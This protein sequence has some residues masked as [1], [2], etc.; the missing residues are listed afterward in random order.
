MRLSAHEIA[1]ERGGRRI[2]SGVSFE[3]RAGKALLLL[4]GASPL[5]AVRH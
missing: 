5:C 1:I 2:F 3:A 4:D